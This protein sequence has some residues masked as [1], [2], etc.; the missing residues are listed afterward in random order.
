MLA[1]DSFSADNL[2]VWERDQ[3]KCRKRQNLGRIRKVYP[4]GITLNAPLNGNK[5]G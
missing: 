4:V 2:R 5:G 1:E 3:G